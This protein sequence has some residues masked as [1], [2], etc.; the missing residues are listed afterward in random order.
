MGKSE[1][2]ESGPPALSERGAR[3]LLNHIIEYLQYLQ[4]HQ[5]VQ[6]LLA[7][8][9]TKRSQ[10]NNSLMS[11]RTQNK[12]TR[13]RLRAEMMRKFDEG[14]RDD[15][16]ILWQ[17]YVPA[18]MLGL[19][20]ATQKMEFYL[21]VY[22]AIYPVLPSSS[23]LVVTPGGGPGGYRNSPHSSSSRHELALRMKAF[24]SYLEGRGAALA[25]T[26]EFLPYYALPFIQQPEHHPSFEPLFQSRWVDRQR[27]E[28]KSLLEGLTAR[29]SVPLLYVMY[30]EHLQAT[31]GV[32]RLSPRGRALRASSRA[33]PSSR[34]AAARGSAANGAFPP[35]PP[36]HHHNHHGFRASG[37]P[38]GGGGAGGILQQYSPAHPHPHPQEQQQQQQH[39][40]SEGLARRAFPAPLPLPPRGS[41]RRVSGS[42]SG[43]S[44]GP[45][46]VAVSAVGLERRS[47]LGGPAAAPL[48]AAPPHGVGGG[49]FGY[50]GG[51][52][53]AEE[54]GADRSRRRDDG[55][56]QEEE[57][58]GGGSGGGGGDGGGLGE[59]KEDTWGLGDGVEDYDDEP[60]EQEIAEALR[61]HNSADLP[62]HGRG[63]QPPPPGASAA[64]LAPSRKAG[65]AAAGE[66]A[67]YA[68]VGL[69][70]EQQL[71]IAEGAVLRES[72][73]LLENTLGGADGSGRG[74]GATLA[75]GR[76]V[77]AEELLAPGAGAGAAAAVSFDGD[78]SGSW[79]GSTTALAPLDYRRVKRDLQGPDTDLA[80]RLLQALR[81]RLTRSRPGADRW[82]LIASWI[83]VDLLH[84]HT[85]LDSFQPPHPPSQPQRQPDAAE[86]SAAAAAASTLPS[87]PQTAAGADAAAPPSRPR[88]AAG[89]CPT[90]ATGTATATVAVA[91][92]AAGR[93]SCSLLQVL[94]DST[95]PRVAE[96]AARL[97]NAIASDRLG[98]NYLML[99]AGGAVQALMGVLRRF[100]P[101]SPPQQAAP[102]SAISGSVSAGGGGGEGAAEQAGTEGGTEA[103]LGGAGGAAVRD[104]PAAQQ[105]LV[106]LQ[107]LSLKRAAQSQ[108]VAEGA[109]Q[110]VVDFLQD[111]RTVSPTAIEYGTA[112]LMN[113]CLRSCGRVAAAS[114]AVPLLRLC[115]SLLNCDN[116][117]VHTY[118]NGTLYSVFSRAAI[119]EAA[120]ARR[121][122]ELLEEVAQS[123]RPPFAAQCQYILRQLYMPDLSEPELEASDDDAAPDGDADPEG[124]EGSDEAYADVDITPE[125][126]TRRQGEPRGEELL[127]GSGYLASSR[128]AREHLGAVRCSVA[129]AAAA[130]AAAGM[131]SLRGS[132]LLGTLPQQPQKQGDNGPAAAVMT[133]SLGAS[134]SRMLGT[135][136]GATTMDLGASV[137]EEGEE[138]GEREEEEEEGE[139]VALVARAEGGGAAEE[140]AAEEE[141]KEEEEEEEE[142]QE[143]AEQDATGVLDDGEEEAIAVAATIM[144][145][146]AAAAELNN[147]NNGDSGPEAQAD[148]DEDAAA[149]SGG[150]AAAAMPPPPPPP[151]AS[152]AED[153][154]PSPTPVSARR[155]RAK[156]VP[157]EPGDA[158][159]MGASGCGGGASRP[160]SSSLASSSAYVALATSTASTSIMA[161]ARALEAARL[162][163]TATSGVA[164]SGSMRRRSYIKPVTPTSLS[165]GL[166]PP[167]GAAESGVDGDAAAAAAATVA[168]R[169]STAGAA[170]VG[171]ADARDSVVGASASVGRSSA[172]Q[173][174]ADT[175]GL[176]AVAAAAAAS[177]RRRQWELPE[178]DDVIRGSVAVGVAADSLMVTDVQ[179]QP[180]GGAAAPAEAAASAPAGPRGVSPTARPQSRGLAASLGQHPRP[181]TA[182][183]PEG[184]L[185][186]P[187]G[188]LAMM[189]S[190]ASLA[191]RP[192]S[193]PHSPFP[194]AEMR[195]SSG[196][197]ASESGSQASAAETGTVAAAGARTG[198]GGGGG[199]GGGG[200]PGTP[201]SARLRR[202]ASASGLAAAAPGEAANLTEEAGGGDEGGALPAASGPP[203]PGDDRPARRPS[204]A[205]ARD[206]GYDGDAALCGHR[207]AVAAS[208]GDAAAEGAVTAGSRMSDN[209]DEGRRRSAASSRSRPST[210]APG[211]RPGSSA[212]FRPDAVA[213]PGPSS[214]DAAGAASPPLLRRSSRPSSPTM[215]PRRRSIADGAGVD[216]GPGGNG[217]P[218]GPSAASA[219]G[220]SQPQQ[221]DASQARTLPQSPPLNAGGGAAA[222]AATGGGGEAKAGAA[223]ATKSPS[224]RTGHA[225]GAQAHSHNRPNQH[226]PPALNRQPSGSPSPEQRARGIP[227]P[228][229]P[230]G[231]VGAAAM[232]SGVQGTSYR[233]APTPLPASGADAPAAGVTTRHPTPPGRA[234]HRTRMGP[235]PSVPAAAAGA[236]ASPP[237]VTGPGRSDTHGEPRRQL[238]R[239]NSGGRA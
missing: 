213:L 189:A 68:S 188:S 174:L 67:V 167:W 16:F 237:R 153:A 217:P 83:E 152:A 118:V 72:V 86:D 155:S 57:E 8:R 193:R 137:L 10:L 202:T 101:P 228:P 87:R 17:Q 144:T 91:T 171:E 11:A 77:L 109:V 107:K 26:A 88:T 203:G 136:M 185:E 60:D 124:E 121:T 23:V 13:E 222:V 231:L 104:G 178:D 140:A 208:V 211:S 62:P 233:T 55:F 215:P 223:A 89:S 22:F 84:C 49:G 125:S 82:G 96:E 238:S 207:S 70:L 122:P 239:N 30:C 157:L 205:A 21:Q 51:S 230:E 132:V 127:C 63:S 146:A 138:E 179:Q 105:A 173:G 39:P 99:P 196:R 147:S 108:M 204:T 64:A 37:A 161:A 135:S 145:A 66:P 139:G 177:T 102:A 6:T 150:E 113:L 172:Q 165:L 103:G 163:G 76:S 61:S 40:N 29:A 7:E 234:A 170:A 28:L 36:P 53:D 221:Q 236:A 111:L 56:A 79:L 20:F 133:T 164:G 166:Q 24:K 180:A 175:A 106:A 232:G 227:R 100:A 162:S 59:S 151:L 123:G 35:P 71:G 110:W 226:P 212:A 74:G 90:A 186:A 78:G 159:L 69:S 52:D 18:S 92:V 210:A 75:G 115:E 168:V 81:W 5:T 43:A 184:S 46:S 93:P 201:L 34:E 119:R 33:H 114:C 2:P 214:P 160:S 38:A 32:P 48:R 42:G 15:F 9:A 12:D 197:R 190:T 154:C 225:S 181:P 44:S 95:D 50:R 47:G 131:S 45:G 235:P 94:A 117:Q 187:P 192:P 65:A 126:I 31:D 220:G 98:R 183:H 73:Q 19:D 116:D 169:P 41:F 112:L 27:V 182:P 120:L 206:E 97:A 54:A 199:G 141:E 209:G 58:A 191:A 158:P 1:S 143:A 195:S 14:R 194:P 149:G 4:Y 130:M 176:S 80:A 218:A 219:G 25:H 148:G 85:P 156:A 216:G 128:G 229:A 224:R 198:T 200:A 142:E 134:A 3:D 129:A